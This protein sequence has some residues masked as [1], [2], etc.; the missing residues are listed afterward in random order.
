MMK[1]EVRILR[2]SRLKIIALLLVCLAFTSIGTFMILDEETMGWF[3][4]I[5]SG[6]GVVVFIIQL[7]PNA[8]YLML[9]SEGFEVKSLFRGNF[10]KWEDVTG[11]AA[12]RISSN[13]TVVF[14]YRKT[15]Q[16]YKVGKQ[17]ARGLAGVEGALP[18]TYGMKAKDLA[19]LMNEWMTHKE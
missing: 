15:H 11:F 6:L 10:T 18:D 7:L 9:T 17:I 14:N 13:K 5:F 1:Q 4:S 8:S 19:A 2:P 16:K 12:G 3:V